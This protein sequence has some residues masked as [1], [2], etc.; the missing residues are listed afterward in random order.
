M[1]SWRRTA[2]TL[3]GA[4]DRTSFG[5]LA[6][7]HNTQTKF[8]L[9]HHHDSLPGHESWVLSVT[10]H[11]N[12]TAFASGGSDSKVKLWDLGARACVQTST[13]HNNQVILFSVQCMCCC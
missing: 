2:F 4:T 3:G 6:Q 1:L 13:D 12:G 8:Y 10:A 7:L 5:T 9:P 11:P